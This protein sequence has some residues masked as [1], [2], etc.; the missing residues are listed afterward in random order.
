MAR[1]LEEARGRERASVKKVKEDKGVKEMDISIE[2]EKEVGE[3]SEIEKTQLGDD[4]V[5]LVEAKT[6]ER[7]LL[8][9]GLKGRKPKLSEEK[10]EEILT[11]ETIR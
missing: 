8:V 2:E 1:L 10:K 6:A 7:G 5:R 11:E 9:H 4:N 3:N